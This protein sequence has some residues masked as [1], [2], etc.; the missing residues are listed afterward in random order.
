MPEN[1]GQYLFHRQRAN[2]QVNMHVAYDAYVYMYMYLLEKNLPFLNEQSNC[3]RILFY[4][5]AAANCSLKNVCCILSYLNIANMQI[6]GATIYGYI[7]Y[8]HHSV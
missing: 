7:G 4:F 1:G 5:S 8:N 6:A 3:T 2:K